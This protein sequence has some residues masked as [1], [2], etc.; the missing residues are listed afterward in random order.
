[1][2]EKKP[3]AEGIQPVNGTHDI[4]FEAPDGKMRKADVLDAE[5][6]Q[7]LTAKS[8]FFSAMP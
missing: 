8:A 3:A 7:L 2:A 1:M 4:K 5:G 6:V